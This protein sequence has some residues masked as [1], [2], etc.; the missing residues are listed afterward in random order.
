MQWNFREKLRN[1]KPVMLSGPD[2]TVLT[3]A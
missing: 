1:D 3:A 2:R